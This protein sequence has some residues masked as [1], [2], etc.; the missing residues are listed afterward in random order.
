MPI[1]ELDET[2]ELGSTPELGE[3]PELGADRA[4]PRLAAKPAAVPLVAVVPAFSGATGDDVL[5]RARL[6]LGETY[7]LG[8]RAP[9]A[10]A[11]W[12]GPWDCAEFVSW[13]VFQASGIVYGAR[14]RNDPMLADAFTG[15]WADDADAGG[16]AVTVEEAAAIAGAAVLRKPVGGQ[17]GHIVVSDGQGGSVEAH[18]SARGVVADRLSGRRWDLGILVP[19]IRYFRAETLPRL[20][21]PAG[22]LRLTTPLMRGE[23]IR[24]LQQR[25]EALK[26]ATG[27]AD[28]VFGPQTAT[29]VRTFQ[30]RAG[31]LADGEVG[32]ATWSE[33]GL[34]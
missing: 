23:R 14:P 24:K 19:G 25:L 2:P 4:P 20:E 18:S 15:F 16:N 10:N 11:G 7:V 12:R 33:L 3:T 31:L 13:C 21:V 30:A 8:A 6:H 17:I 9:L 27:T 1:R 29:A 26:L 34:G 22:I 32:A 5:A 28:G